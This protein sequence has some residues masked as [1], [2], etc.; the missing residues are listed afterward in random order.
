MN[1]MVICSYGF[2]TEYSWEDLEEEISI[3]GGIE[4]PRCYNFSQINFGVK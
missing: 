4:L 2:A 1:R 3:L